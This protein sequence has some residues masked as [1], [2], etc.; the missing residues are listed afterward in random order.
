ME[1]TRVPLVVRVL[2][3]G[4]PCRKRS[5]STR[6]KNVWIFDNP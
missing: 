5:L 2:Q 3:V 6:L 4:N 1:V